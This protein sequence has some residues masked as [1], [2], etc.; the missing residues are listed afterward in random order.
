MTRLPSGLRRTVLIIDDHPV[1]RL[2]LKHLLE[3]DGHY[4]VVGEAHS[5]STAIEA[6]RVQ[7]PDI[8]ILDLV[9]G[10]GRGLEL[11]PSLRHS[12]PQAQI[13]VI[14]MLDELLYAERCLLLGANGYLMKSRASDQL[15]EALQVLLDGRVFV[16]DAVKERLVNTA[17]QGQGGAR[18][19]IELLTDRELEVFQLIGSG[20]STVE[21]GEILRL[22]VKTVESHQAKLRRKL[23]VPNARELMRLAVSWYAPAPGTLAPR[24]TEPVPTDPS[25]Q[26]SLNPDLPPPSTTSGAGGR[27]L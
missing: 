7:Q 19:Q 27:S 24:L 9:L 23:N 16:T 14:S 12:H 21:I 18:S 6:A 8:I 20:K 1:M 26:G 15:L 5:H 4:L 25:R 17:I 22:S 10:D 11:L 2:G 3:G 13:L